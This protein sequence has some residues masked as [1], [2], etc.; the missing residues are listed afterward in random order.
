MKKKW[1]CRLNEKILG[2]QWN[3]YVLKQAVYNEHIGEDSVGITVSTDKSIFFCDNFLTL[4]L[5]VHELMHAFIDELCIH[6]SQLSGDQFEEI[7]C[8]LMA[9]HG[10]SVLDTSERVYK[11][12]KAKL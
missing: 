7:A 12:M 5:V 8:E 1:L 6:A 2:K 4:E 10:K 3:I 9:K 11:R